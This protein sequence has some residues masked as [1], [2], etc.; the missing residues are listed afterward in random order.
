MTDDNWEASQEPYDPGS[1]ATSSLGSTVMVWY[2][3]P[4]ILITL[5][6]LVVLAVSVISD[7]PRH[8]TKAQDASE[9]NDSIHQIN[10]DI[11]PC[12]FAVTQSFSF[13]EEQVT[14]KLSASNKKQIPA[15]LVGDQ[16]ACSFAS[17]GVYDL[18]SNIQVN[19]T[20][21]G[22]HIDS[23]LS[24]IVFWITE[25]SLAAIEDIQY[26]F[27]H[28]NDAKKIRNLS[29]QETLLG[30]DRVK[31]FSDFTAA[32]RVVGL[33]LKNPKIPSLPSLSGT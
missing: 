17:G 24:V 19:D 10:T 23:M 4:W 22:I 6:I 7:L 18:T 16:T 13:Y 5:G 12:V 31:I 27:S 14:G 25:D 8:I 9:Q 2:K 28:P 33:T 1:M 20:T 15:L 29:K 21:A 26:L 30:Q 32:E 11:A 3:R